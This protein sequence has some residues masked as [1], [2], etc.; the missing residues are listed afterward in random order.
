MTISI[1][2]YYDDYKMIFQIQHFFHI[3]QLILNILQ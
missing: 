2:L 3:H 1:S